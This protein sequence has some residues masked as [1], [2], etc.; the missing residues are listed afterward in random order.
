MSANLRVAALPAAACALLVS[1]AAPLPLAGGPPLLADLHKLLLAEPPRQAALEARADAVRQCLERKDEVV[2]EVASGRLGLAE[3]A[4]RFERLD[5]ELGGPSLR[6]APV[7]LVLR[8]AAAAHKDRPRERAA[9]LARLQR[10]REAL[11]ARRA[12]R[13]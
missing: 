10:E 9:L 4:A 2:R 12:G 13:F 1:L 11:L 3:A 7:D 8:W 6:L 5:A